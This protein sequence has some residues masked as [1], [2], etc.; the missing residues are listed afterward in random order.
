MIVLEDNSAVGCGR[1][2]E[3]KKITY[4]SMYNWKK[5][6]YKDILEQITLDLAY[7]ILFISI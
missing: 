7:P 6:C 3:Y 5:S 1:V 2:S 4:I